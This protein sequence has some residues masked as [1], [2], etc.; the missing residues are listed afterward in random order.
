MDGIEV[1]AHDA[2]SDLE[3]LRSELRHSTSDRSNE[4]AGQAGEEHGEDV[5]AGSHT[6]ECDRYTQR[7]GEH[8]PHYRTEGADEDS[9]NGHW[10]RCDA[11][12]E[13]GVGL[14]FLQEEEA[15]A[16]D[17]NA[18][19]DGGEEDS[20]DD[21]DGDRKQQG[22]AMGYPSADRTRNLWLMRSNGSSP[23]R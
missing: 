5:V 18:A 15:E 10:R 14:S 13:A 11:P 20:R 2:V 23:R 22:A 17:G 4:E 3:V 6:L 21:V 8:H 9:S 16:E 7:V 19:V 1:Q 12:G